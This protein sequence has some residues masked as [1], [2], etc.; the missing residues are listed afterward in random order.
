MKIAISDCQVQLYLDYRYYMRQICPNGS[1]RHSQ[2]Q[3]YPQNDY[4]SV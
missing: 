4:I 3:I 2:G 1:C